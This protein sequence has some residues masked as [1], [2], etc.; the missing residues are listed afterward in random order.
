MATLSSA[1][2]RKGLVRCETRSLNHKTNARRIDSHALL[3]EHML[4]GLD[5]SHRV[6][7]TEVERGRKNDSIDLRHRHDLL[8]AVGAAEREL[9]VHAELLGGKLCLVEEVVG[10]SDRLD[11]DVDTLL[12]EN[13]RSLHHVAQRAELVEVLSIRRF[14]HSACTASAAADDCDL[15]L[16][17]AV[18]RGSSV[19]RH[20]C[21]SKH[22]S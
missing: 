15:E 13:C 16:L 1:H 10:E 20:S 21:G 8:V 6:D 7:R 19:R 12:A 5:C 11:R 4:T 2:D 9:L 18:K 17:L 22:R 3:R 14:P